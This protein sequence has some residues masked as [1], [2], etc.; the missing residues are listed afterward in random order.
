MVMKDGQAA[1]VGNFEELM[2]RKGAFCELKQLQ[3]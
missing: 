1:E 2:S 3:T